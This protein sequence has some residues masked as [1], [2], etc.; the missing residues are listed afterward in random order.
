MGL[1]FWL[2]L[3]FITLYRNLHK[4]HY[5]FEATFYLL[6][7]VNECWQ[8]NLA[9]TDPLLR[10]DSGENIKIDKNFTNFSIFIYGELHDCYIIFLIW[11]Q[12]GS[13]KC[14]VKQNAQC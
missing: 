8:L 7:N 4:D 13:T 3:R 14:I 11:L 6:L 12:T 1:I 10:H 5:V 2:R 9:I